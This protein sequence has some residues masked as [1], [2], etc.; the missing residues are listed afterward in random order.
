M[1]VR[2]SPGPWTFHPFLTASEN[3]K[4]WVVCARNG[5]NRIAEVYPHPENGDPEQEANA[6]LI[7]SAPD[8]KRQ[9]DE[10]L[11]VAKHIIKTWETPRFDE[12]DQVHLPI[13]ELRAVVAECE[14]EE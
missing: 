6:A 2:H 5:H 1:S 13:G 7:A 8:L 12:T 3:H 9:R 11:A 10:L 4:G 14:I